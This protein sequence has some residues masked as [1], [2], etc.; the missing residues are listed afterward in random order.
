MRS[1]AGR[2][3]LGAR[4]LSYDAVGSTRPDAPVWADD[5]GGYRRYERTVPVGHGRTDWEEA[6]EL[7]MTWGVKT[8]SG[9][10]VH[11]APEAGRPPGAGDEVWLRAR[12]GPFTVREPARVVAVVDEPDRRGFAY[13]TLEGHPVCGEEAFVVHRSAD[14]T[15]WLT[16]RS[17]TRAPRGPW[18]VAYPAALVAQ[19]W[20]RRRYLRALVRTGGS[21]RRW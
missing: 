16:L 2:T 7:L 19:R 4:R 17:L 14:G 18:R 13:G 3:P 8:R 5:V 10:S 6:S 21:G 12:V 1:A 9:F 11:P 15:V 20:Y